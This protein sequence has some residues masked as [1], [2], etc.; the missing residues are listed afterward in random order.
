MNNSTITLIL[1]GLGNSGAEH[2]QTL[3]EQADPSCRRVQQDNWDTPQ[4]SDWVARLESTMQATEGD[5][6]FAAHSS[7]CAM[8]IV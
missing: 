8:T 7:S 6:V 5:V 4:C 1:P 2:W 3:W